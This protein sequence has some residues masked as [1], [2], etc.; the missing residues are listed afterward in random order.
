[1]VWNRGQNMYS[2]LL[3]S[4]NVLHLLHI[5]AGNETFLLL[6]P[7]AHRFMG[8]WWHR[9]MKRGSEPQRGMKMRPGL[10]IKRNLLLLYLFSFSPVKMD[11][12]TIQ[13]G[14][15]TTDI[16]LPVPVSVH[17]S[18]LTCLWRFI[19]PRPSA[20]K[21]CI[22]ISSIFNLEAECRWNRRRVWRQQW[23]WWCSG[24][25]LLCGCPSFFVVHGGSLLS[26]FEAVLLLT[27][28]RRLSAAMH[29]YFNWSCCFFLSILGGGLFGAFCQV[30]RAMELRPSGGLSPQKKRKKNWA[31][32][33]NRQ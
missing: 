6:T 33:L 2:E 28:K 8:K 7:W 32:P 31:R 12:N 22:N 29:S 17:Q 10:N 1:M 15:H 5:F 26:G 16:I 14:C 20:T 4:R 21:I 27:G 18:E 9:V 30:S 23:W 24:G 3:S 13:H 11:R 19:S 25:G